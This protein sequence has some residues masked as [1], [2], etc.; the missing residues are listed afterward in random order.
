MN[1]VMDWLPFKTDDSANQRS[2]KWLTNSAAI[3]FTNTEGNVLDALP[4]IPRTAKNEQYRKELQQV[5]SLDNLER[6]FAARM[7][8]G[9]RNNNMIKYAMALV[10]SGIDL[11]TIS[12]Q[13]HDFNKKL[14]NPLPAE[15]IDNTVMR[16]VA[17]QFQP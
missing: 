9:N 12:K 17:R 15:E 16:T 4:F 2:K 11:L 7:A 1:A 10:D 5:Q 6:W 3:C 8:S 14:S 13:V